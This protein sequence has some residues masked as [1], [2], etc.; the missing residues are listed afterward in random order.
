MSETLFLK[1]VYTNE[2]IAILKHVDLKSPLQ[3]LPLRISSEIT[4]LSND[5]FEFIIAG[6]AIKKKQEQKYK[7]GVCAIRS[8]DGKLYLDLTC[9]NPMTTAV[10]IVADTVDTLT[11]QQ[12]K[13][14]FLTK[15]KPCN[16]HVKNSDD[17]ELSGEQKYDG[18]SKGT[19]TQHTYPNF[20]SAKDIEET[21][22]TLEKE[23]KIFSNSKLHQIIEEGSLHDWGIQAIQGVID[24]HWVL[25]KND[26]LK[27]CVK[28]LINTTKSTHLEKDTTLQEE[29]NLLKNLDELSRRISTKLVSKNKNRKDLEKSFDETFTKLKVTQSNLIKSI[30][31]YK[32]VHFKQKTL[33]GITD[34]RANTS[35]ES[36]EDVELS[37]NEMNLLVSSVKDDF[38]DN[39]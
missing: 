14:S 30:D 7:V 18:T 15:S 32:G 3:N 1:N 26:L 22:E 13:N 8:A 20:Y 2:V 25:R 21:T 34:I 38:L 29:V 5:A 9:R 23:R 12:G 31:H 33:S 16:C 28:E 39:L 36:N 37:D 24:V 10:S 11:D 6:T 35:T 19:G 17:G 4:L 27:N